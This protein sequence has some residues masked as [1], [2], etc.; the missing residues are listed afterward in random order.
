MAPSLCLAV[1]PGLTTGWVLFRPVTRTK[2]DVVRW[3]ETRGEAEFEAIAWEMN[4]QE[5]VS[6]VVCEEFVPYHDR[7]RTWEPEALHIIGTLRFIFGI[8][9]VNLRQ[10]PSDAYKY[11]DAGHCKPYQ[12]GYKHEA[13]GYGGEGHAIMALAHGLIWTANSWNGL[14]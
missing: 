11:R 10:R 5:H 4:R 14:T 13:V 6:R 12:Q 7:H 8:K 3:G 1:D 9:N 2:M